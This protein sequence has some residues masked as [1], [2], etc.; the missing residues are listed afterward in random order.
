MDL[1]FYILQAPVKDDDDDDDDDDAPKQVI[2][3]LVGEF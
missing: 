3:T 2:Q 1:F